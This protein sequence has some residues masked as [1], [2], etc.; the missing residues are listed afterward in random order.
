MP[1]KLINKS[2][3][4][5]SRKPG[6]PPKNSK[7]ETPTE[8]VT[9]PSN[10]S[11]SV[12]DT[13]APKQTPTTTP[14]NTQLRVQV[15]RVREEPLAF[16]GLTQIDHG[17]TLPTFE[18][19]SHFA[20]DL[21]SNSSSLNETSK[22]DADKAVESI[23]KKRNTLRIVAA[24]IG[25]NQDV[26]KVSTDYKK[27]EGMVIDYGTVLVNN[28]TKFINFQ[29][30]G[31][32]KDIAANKFEQ[33]NERLLQGEKTLSGMRRITALIDSEWDER[34]SLKKSQISSLK[35]SATEAKQALEP[36]LLQI[37]ESFRQ[38]LDDLN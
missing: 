16:T 11:V 19:N 37:S 25:L 20:G 4:V 35:I 32:N 6:R 27:L 5:G 33:A 2:R 21:F 3:N 26:V 36:K 15:T 23:E 29:T 13:P 10:G 34:V 8:V 38:D 1:R 22:E 24:N 31:V 9:P 28:E 17:L 30:A 12:A 14:T 7:P 18:A